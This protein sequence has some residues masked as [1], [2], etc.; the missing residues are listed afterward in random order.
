MK[1]R[2]TRIY[3]Y[4]YPSMY[5]ISITCHMPGSGL[6]MAFVQSLIDYFIG[7]IGIANL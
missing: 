3:L 4:M 5:L 2:Y 6:F 7:S 1:L